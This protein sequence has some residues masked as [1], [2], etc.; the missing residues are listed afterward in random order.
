[1]SEASEQPKQSTPFQYS[2]WSLFVATTLLAILFG[3]VKWDMTALGA[4]ATVYAL[5]V[6]LL[7]PQ[8]FRRG[9]KRIRVLVILLLLSLP[10][11]ACWIELLKKV[12][13]SPS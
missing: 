3:F 6:L 13:S 10:L 5:P 4:I 11:I 7:W 9:H 2:L 12:F 8:A 1:M